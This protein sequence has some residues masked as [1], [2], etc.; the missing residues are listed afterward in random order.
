MPIVKIISDE[1][2]AAFTAESFL[3]AL[4]LRQDKWWDGDRQKYIFR[5]HQDSSW[6]LVPTAFRDP[7]PKILGEVMK[8]GEALRRE[9]NLNPDPCGVR[10]WAIAQLHYQF[11]KMSVKMGFRGRVKFCDGYP[12]ERTVYESLYNFESFFCPYNLDTRDWD[13]AID[14]LALAQHHGIPTSLIDWTLNPLY[15]LHFATRDWLINCSQTP[16]A[17]YAHPSHGSF[18]QIANL[19]DGEI[20]REVAVVETDLAMNKYAFN[21]NGCFTLERINDVKNYYINHGRYYSIDEIEKIEDENFFIYKYILSQSEVPRLRMMLDRVGI[22]DNML[23]PTLDK[24]TETIELIWKTRNI[25][26]RK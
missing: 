13:S 9:N 17:V 18:S 14:F 12:Q 26:W 20:Q 25:S 1:R 24:A 7:A 2:G 19:P 23:M 3:D 6:N 11:A 16:I 8:Y 22:M 10:L 4:S 15:A 5:G 21:Q